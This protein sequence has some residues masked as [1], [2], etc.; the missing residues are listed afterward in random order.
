[1]K[2]KHRK[3]RRAT[4][5]REDTVMVISGKDKGRT[6]RVITVDWRRERLL[7]EGVNMVTRHTKPNAANQKGGLIKIEA[8]VHYSNVQ[9]YNPTLERGV[10]VKI[11]TSDAGVKNRVCVKSGEVL[12]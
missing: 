2:T 12:G 7:I 3:K 5:R 10:R 11:L 8:P 1:M 4:I 6:G 9:L